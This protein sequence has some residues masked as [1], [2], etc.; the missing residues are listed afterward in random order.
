MTA[1]YYGRFR[2]KGRD[3]RHLIIG[4]VMGVI[5]MTVLMCGMNLLLTPLY[6]GMPVSA[7]AAMIVPVIL[8]FNLLKAGINALV[9]FLL[10]L[11]LRKA[12]ARAEENG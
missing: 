12:L 3:M 8:P 2:R 6:T 5:A 1:V 9:T 10:F 11:P 4:L 7:V